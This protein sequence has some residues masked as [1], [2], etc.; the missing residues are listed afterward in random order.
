MCVCV[1]VCIQHAIYAV[2]G[3]LAL[4]LSLYEEFLELEL[5]VERSLSGCPESCSEGS[6]MS[7]MSVMSVSCQ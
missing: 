6:V 1:S 5:V 7:V 4:S 2:C 3:S